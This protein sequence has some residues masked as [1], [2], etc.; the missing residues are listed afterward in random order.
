MQ[1]GSAGLLLTMTKVCEGRN[2]ILQPIKFLMEHKLYPPP[3]CGVASETCSLMLGNAPFKAAD[4]RA[5][6][7]RAIAAT[8]DI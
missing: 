6:I 3:A 8:Q 2:G 4:R 5:D 7:I 1:P